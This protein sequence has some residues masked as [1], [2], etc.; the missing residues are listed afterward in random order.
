MYQYTKQKKRK[1]QAKKESFSEKFLE[2]FNSSGL[3]VPVG[4]DALCRGKDLIPSASAGAAKSD[5]S[6]CQNELNPSLKASGGEFE[7][8]QSLPSKHISKHTNNLRK[9]TPYVKPS[10]TTSLD[11]SK[12][13]DIFAKQVGFR[14]D[15]ILKT[16]HST[17]EKFGVFMRHTAEVYNDFN[18][19]KRSENILKCSTKF[20]KIKCLDCGEFYAG[21]SVYVCHDRFCPICARKRSAEKASL[22]SLQVK[23]ALEQHGGAS[24]R[25]LTLTLVNPPL[26]ELKEALDLLQASWRKLR[27]T[28][29]FRERVLGGFL[30]LEITY[31]SKTRTWH[32]HL[33]VLLIGRFI[34]QGWLAD[35]WEKYTGARIVDI[36][37]TGNLDKQVKEVVKY[38]TKLTEDSDIF[39]E[40][41]VFYEL[42]KV[43]HGRRTISTF[44]CLYRVS[45]AVK[46]E[47]EFAKLQAVD[48][49]RSCPFCGSRNLIDTGGFYSISIRDGEVVIP[50]AVLEKVERSREFLEYP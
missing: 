28:K 26:G 27:R 41:G 4:S 7:G 44:G 6:F 8:G 37:R 10:L 33:H 20:Q 22:L 30:S 15:R 36:R 17:K 25:F 23:E 13:V 49:E 43:L 42:Q 29:Y 18:L 16:L 14:D 48:K 9:F 50:S 19:F 11:N 35:T 1:S 32:P 46:D 12:Q 47:V 31:N 3:A 40:V 34:E 39:S 5:F 45:E 24:V 38:V 21:A 2:K